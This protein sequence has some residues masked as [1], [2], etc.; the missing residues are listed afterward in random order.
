[1]IINDTSGRTMTD[2]SGRTPTN[3]A[4]WPTPAQN[5]P[6]VLNHFSWVVFFTPTLGKRTRNRE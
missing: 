6:Q 3:R 5:H 4:M 1:M 2:T